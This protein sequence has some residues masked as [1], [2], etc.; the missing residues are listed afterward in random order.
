LIDAT[1][2]PYESANI[3]KDAFEKEGIK[4]LKNGASNYEQI[5]QKDGASVLRV[6]TPVPVVMERCTMCHEHYKKAKAGEPIGAISYSM[7]I[8]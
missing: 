7:P 5:V 2:Q 3:A 4:Q 1:G 8:R 6:M